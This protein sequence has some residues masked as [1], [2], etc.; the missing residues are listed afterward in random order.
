MEED[1]IKKIKKTLEKW[2]EIKNSSGYFI[3]SEESVPD[4]DSRLFKESWVSRV[5]NS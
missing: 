3:L 5:L 2:E 4:G 1:K